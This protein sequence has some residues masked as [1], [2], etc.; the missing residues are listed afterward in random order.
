MLCT[1]D[2]VTLLLRF[3]VLKPNSDG[4]PK[5]SEDEIVAIIGRAEQ[6]ITKD[7]SQVVD[8]SLVPQISDTPATPEPI[9]QMAI[10]KST[11]LILVSVYSAARQVDTITDLQYW[12]KEY[13]Q[14]KEDIL[15][16]SVKLSYVKNGVVVDPYNSGMRFV[17]TDT[18]AQVFGD[19]KYGEAIGP[20]EYTDGFPS[21]SRDD[22]LR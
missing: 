1:P 20:P 21:E 4:S 16:C 8:M 9:H 2:D 6:H 13:D 22:G 7:I 18:E 17:N 10:A 15:E 11:E 19:T 5:M 14:I 3:S 12:K